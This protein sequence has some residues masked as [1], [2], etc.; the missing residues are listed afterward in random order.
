MWTLIIGPTNWQRGYRPKLPE[1]LGTHLPR[2][3]KRR[4]Q[5]VLSPIDIRA[6]L[7]GLLRREGVEA[8]LMEDDPRERGETHTSHFS[9]LVRTHSDGRFFAYWPLH[10]NWPG[11]NWELSHLATRI[12]DKMLQGRQLHLFPEEGVAV[13]DP[14]TDSVIFLEEGSRTTYYDD[15]GNW[16]CEVDVWSDYDS[17]L[18]KVIEAGVEE[19]PTE[20]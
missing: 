10:A 20:G 4:G 13:V 8:V 15:L 9:R 5:D 2:T 17:L 19:P 3:W 16:G 11:L 18:D 7:A 1:G 6:L 14:E 12:D